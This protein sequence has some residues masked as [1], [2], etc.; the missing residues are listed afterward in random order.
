[1][2]LLKKENEIIVNFDVEEDGT[3]RASE[4]LRILTEDFLKFRFQVIKTKLSFF[5]VRI[6]VVNRFR[7]SKT[8]MSSRR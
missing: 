6:S 2:D 3:R 7:V 1:M 4:K 5:K 8:R